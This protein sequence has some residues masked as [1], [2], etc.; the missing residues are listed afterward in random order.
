MKFLI[1]KCLVKSYDILKINEINETVA[2]IT[3]ILI[4]II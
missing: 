3:L 2:H 1:V 4:Y